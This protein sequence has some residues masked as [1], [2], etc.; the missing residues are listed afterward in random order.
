MNDVDSPLAAACDIVL[1]DGGG[2]GAERRGDQIFVAS[3]AMLLRVTAAGRTTTRLRAAI[4]RLPDRLAAAT[5]LDW[6]RGP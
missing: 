6:S 1:A 2:T 3:L 4:E 5:D